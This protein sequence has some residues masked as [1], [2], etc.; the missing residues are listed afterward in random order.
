MGSDI[1]IDD[2]SNMADDLG[3]ALRLDGDCI[4][5]MGMADATPVPRFQ[6]LADAPWAWSMVHCMEVLLYSHLMSRAWL[7]QDFAHRRCT[8]SHGEALFFHLPLDFEEESYCR[9]QLPV[10]IFVQIDTIPL[11]ISLSHA[12][13]DA[14][15]QMH[16]LLL[17]VMLEHAVGF[18]VVMENQINWQLNS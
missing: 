8:G 2:Q 15:N 1:Q 5:R 4:G 7:G 6:E 9:L 16:V 11:L 18:C 13:M 12:R 17:R 10:A 3:R 14:P